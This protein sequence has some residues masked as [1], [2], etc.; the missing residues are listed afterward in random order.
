MDKHVLVESG[1]GIHGLTGLYICGGS[2]FPLI[3]H[4]LDGIIR[5]SELDIGST[6]AYHYYFTRHIAYA[7]SAFKASNVDSCISDKGLHPFI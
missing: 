4:F 6:H 5:V 1:G 7:M 2:D 3:P